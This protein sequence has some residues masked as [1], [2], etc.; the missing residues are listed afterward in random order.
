MLCFLVS[1]VLSSC[2]SLLFLFVFCFVCFLVVVVFLVCVLFFLVVLSSSFLND[3]I[4][5]LGLIFCVGLTFVLVLQ[6][7][8]AT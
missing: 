7:I 6:R 1:V 5:R 3:Y 2:C 4:L 8:Q